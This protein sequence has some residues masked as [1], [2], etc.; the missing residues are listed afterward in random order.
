MMVAGKTDLGK[1]SGIEV[2]TSS[3][4]ITEEGDAKKLIAEIAEQ[5]EK[6]KK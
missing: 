4:A 3:I 6:L 1:A 2:P 5:A